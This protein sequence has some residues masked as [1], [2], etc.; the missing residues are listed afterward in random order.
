MEQNDIQELINHCHEMAEK[1][2]LD[3]G[4]FYPLG[5]YIDIQGEFSYI[6]FHD[7]D[8]FPLSNTVIENLQNYFEKQLQEEAIRAYAVTYD[9]RVTSDDFPDSID[10]VTIYIKHIDFATTTFYYPYRLK[11]NEIDFYEPWAEHAD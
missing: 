4:E 9:S 1:L 11:N 7:G 2:L 3:Q 6:S 8:E 10:C 5:A